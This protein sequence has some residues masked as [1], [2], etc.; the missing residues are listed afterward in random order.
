MAEIRDLV[1]FVPST[2]LA[3]HEGCNQEYFH[4]G[5]VEL[6]RKLLGQFLYCHQ[7]KVVVRIL[8]TEAYPEDDDIVY[9]DTFDAYT[10]EERNAMFKIKG[11]TM[12]AWRPVT[13]VGYHLYITAGEED[14]GDVVY[15]RSC[16][17]IEGRHVVLERRGLNN[18]SPQ[19]TI[20]Q[21][22]I[23]PSKVAQGLGKEWESN[24]VLYEEGGVQLFH[25]TVPPREKILCGIR[26][27]P[28]DLSK[29]N[30]GNMRFALEKR[31]PT[32]KYANKK[33]LKHLEQ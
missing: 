20:N 16:E 6:A 15:L 9:D 14:C 7:S 33:T 1:P 22:L 3:E 24:P 25:G 30:R 27:L 2:F 12:V 23:G 19:T 10:I 29:V 28:Y 11:G 5:A 31:N 8:E 26:Y 4:C 32:P 21:V 18:E 13:S 17:P